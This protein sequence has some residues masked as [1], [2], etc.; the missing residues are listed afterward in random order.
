M[1]LLHDLLAPPATPVSDEQ[2]DPLGYYRMQLAVTVIREVT[3]LVPFLKRAVKA[4]VVIGLAALLIHTAAL[5][6]VVISPDW[7]PP[8]VAKWIAVGEGGGLLSLGL[9]FLVRGA[10]RHLAARPAPPA[11]SPE[12]KDD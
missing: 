11:H 6:V 3:S 10:L 1:S 5:A 2:V 4:L 12:K 7:F 8:P 9:A